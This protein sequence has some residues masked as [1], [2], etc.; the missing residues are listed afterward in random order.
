MPASHDPNYKTP[1]FPSLYWLI[2]P[3]DVVKP[4]YLYHVKDSWRFTLF[5]TLII[6]EAAHLLAATYAVIIVW[7]GGRSNLIKG[8]S[9]GKAG[10][11][12]GWKKLRVLWMVPIVYGVVAGVE[13][14]LAGSVV[15]LMCVNR[16]GL[17][18][19]PGTPFSMASDEE[20]DR[21]AV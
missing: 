14:L 10:G 8:K 6:Y 16:T 3:E 9:S 21:M 19:T 1:P 20:A 13:A 18:F 5:W 15:G 7:S 4:A 17:L 12:G 11:I 2:G